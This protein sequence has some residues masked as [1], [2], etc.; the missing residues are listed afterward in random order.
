MLLEAA[1]IQQR[2]ATLPPAWTTNGTTLFYEAT[3]EDFVAAIAFVNSLVEPAEALDHH[4]DI[5]IRYNQVTLAITTH[6]AGGLTELDFELAT[7]IAHL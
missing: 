3:F 4:P 7:R 5:T 6:D 1:A 2:L